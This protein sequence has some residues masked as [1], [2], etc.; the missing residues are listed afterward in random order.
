MEVDATKSLFGR[1]DTG[2]LGFWVSKHVIKT[3]NK[4]F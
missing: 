4:N 2:C 3:L 1:R